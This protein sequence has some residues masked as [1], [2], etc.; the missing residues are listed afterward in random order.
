MPLESGLYL[1]A[2]PIGNAADITLRALEVL[3]RADALAAEDTRQTR[4][5]MEMHGIAL[6]GRPMISYNDRNGVERRPRILAWLRDGMS[7][8]YCSDAGT[9]LV[10][11]PG[12]RLA[13]MA[14]AEGMGLTAI[15]GASAVLTALSLAGLPTDRFLFAGF[16]PPKRGARKKALD[17]LAAVPATL[18]FYESPRRLA[19][20]LADMAAMLGDLRPAAVARELT[21]K[22]EQVRRGPLG[23][24]A[25]Q[26]AAEDAPKGEVVVLVG[27]P[28]A[29]V[30]HAKSAASLDD[31]LAEALLT[32]S[33]KDAAR[34][35]AT[36]LDLPRRDV[37][38]RALEL[39]RP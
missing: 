9:P 11:D 4:K 28:D 23:E 34:A 32:L 30:A 27:P 37:Y 31:A 7:V 3:A 16:L 38:A 39:A 21:K 6:A 1:V 14:V 17:E 8:A 22:F 20:A 19:S 13:E 35:V 29:G 18:I 15:P 24:L 36:S 5:L 33:I 12:Y 25:A 10:A 2:T 26:Y